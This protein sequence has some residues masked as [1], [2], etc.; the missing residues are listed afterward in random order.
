MGTCMNGYLSGDLGVGAGMGPVG[1]H[2][3]RHSGCMHLQEALRGTPCRLQTHSATA[4]VCL[5]HAHLHAHVHVHMSARMH[6][7]TC[8]QT[9]MAEAEEKSSGGVL[10]TSQ[11][12]EKPNFGT[13]V[14]VGAGRK[15]EDGEVSAPN[16]AV[17]STVM[18]SKYSGT[19]FE[20]EDLGYI[21]ISEGDVLAALS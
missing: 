20:E 12:A 15:K 13:V 10:L 1:G 21:I 19:E 6:A 8:A 17:G 4:L 5:L 18:Y 9:Q 11:S 7:H 2:Q 14:S 3:R 16:V